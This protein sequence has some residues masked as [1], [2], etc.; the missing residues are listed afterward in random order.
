MPN[1]NSVSVF[2]PAYN[3]EATIAEMVQDALAVL[4]QLTNDYEVIVVNDGSRDSTPAV[5]DRLARTEPHVK[6]IH[7]L[8][9]KGYGAALRTGIAHATREMIFYT[10]GDG[11]YDVGELTALVPLM[12]EEVDVVNGYKRKRADHAY[13]RAIGALYNQTARL[14]FRLPIRD[15]DCDFRLIRRASIERVRL[16]SS[17]GVIC[18]EMVRKLHVAGCVFAEAEVSH[19]PRT[20]GQSQFFTL[21]RVART[22]FDFLALWIRLV[23]WPNPFKKAAQSRAAAVIVEKRRLPL[24]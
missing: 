22:I 1:F 2:F 19:Y 18:V 23:V 13:R 8:R 4:P 12:T 21:P 24:G 3:D 11:Q 16:E 7:H 10:D 15:V 6:V 17:S 5:L 9:N 14:L 20:H